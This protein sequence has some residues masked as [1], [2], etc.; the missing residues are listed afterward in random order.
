MTD[1]S[2]ITWRKARGSANN[3]S[4]VEVAIWRRS[5]R[6]TQQ[7]DHSK[8]ATAEAV[9]LTRDSKDPDGPVL[10]FETDAWGTFLDIVKSGRLD[11]R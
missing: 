5:S 8:I 2:Q 10:G 6:S 11:L 9:L 3:G 7:G 1:L 4:C